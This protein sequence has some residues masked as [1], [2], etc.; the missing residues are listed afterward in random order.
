MR[1]IARG[2]K[3]P[4]VI[5]GYGTSLTAMNGG[6]KCDPFVPDGPYRNRIQY[7]QRYPE[8]AE[9]IELH[10]NHDG[11]GP[12]HVRVGINWSFK[13]AI[14]KKTRVPV[15]YLN[16]GISG[17][18]A[19]EGL[20][21]NG[22]RN[23]GDQ[24]RLEAVNRLGADLVIIEYCMNDLRSLDLRDRLKRMIATLRQPGTDLLVLGAPGVPDPRK[25]ALRVRAEAAARGAAEE[26]DVAFVPF[27]PLFDDEGNMVKPRIKRA[28]LCPA[29]R[30]NHPGP[31]EFAAYGKWL[32]NIIL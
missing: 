11:A 31:A 16:M 1:R 6:G 32:A 8:I 18:N 7:F 12:V 15:T 20:S 9:R 14:E 3:E 25:L 30:I 23:G 19:G 27:A 22:D 10:D 5:V 29:N 28:D 13:A 4:V 21:A 2:Q 17:T 26:S 24:Q